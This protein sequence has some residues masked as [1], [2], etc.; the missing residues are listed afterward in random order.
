MRVRVVMPMVLLAIVIL[1]IA[2][3]SGQAARASDFVRRGD[4]YRDQYLYTAARDQYLQAL[5]HRPGDPSLWLRL[6]QIEWRLARL[7]D[8][9][10]SAE[11]AEAAGAAPADVAECR[12]R[13]ADSSGQP[14]LAAEQWSIVAADRPGDRSARIRSIESLAAAH[15]WPAATEAARSMVAQLP[16][17]PEASFFLGALLSL[18]EPAQARSVLRASS[19]VEAKALSAVLTNPLGETDRAYRAVSV[20]RLFLDSGRLHL[21][22]RAFVDAASANPAYPDAFAYLGITYAE[23]GQPD[24][25]EAHLDRALELDPRS[26]LGLYL[27]GLYL[28]HRTDWEDARI[29]LARAAELEP[30]NAA[31]AVALGQALA[32]Q[33]QYVLAEEWLNRAT[34]VDPE[35]PAW[36]L[37][38]AEFYVGRLIHVDDKG[39]PVARR[40]VELA[41]E[42]AAARDWLGWGLHL[43][44]DPAQGEVELR[45][46]LALDST[47][48]RARLHL[49]NLLVDTGRLEEGRTE[50]QRALDLDPLGEVGARAKQLLGIP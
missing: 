42:S 15:H 16:D 39:V 23:L 26:A 20:G 24:L 38:L 32:G 34:V 4:A 28:L 46:A 27:R 29:D 35:A 31:V 12:A 47:F 40:A 25:A 45:V 1:A 41:P 17:D 7:S 3:S 44:G 8:A 14:E 50:L 33:G 48:A 21:A 6:C 10:R 37:A 9:S 11:R 43:S 13:I 49:G 19:L 18:D 36:Q 2:F 5:D 30:S 22:W